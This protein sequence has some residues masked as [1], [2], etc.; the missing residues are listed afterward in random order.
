MKKKQFS[1]DGAKGA[2][3][4]GKIHLRLEAVNTAIERGWSPSP[5]ERKKILKARARALA[6]EPHKE[7]TREERKEILEFLLANE[8]YGI[9]SCYVREVYPLRELT[10]V[11]CTPPFVLG[12]INVRGRILP[13]IDIKKFF[14]LPQKGLTD[15]NK[16]IILQRN[17]M[18]IG[19]LSDAILGNRS[20]SLKEMQSSLP[21]LTDI[22]AEY[23]MGVTGERMVILDAAKILSDKRM[24]VHEQVEI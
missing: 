16:V 15:L 11:P 24:I 3:D 9:E 14:D 19:I 6:L 1:D 13:V 23:L 18:E 17:G 5:E 7:A 12:I 2:I 4:W 21:T 8:T 10:P 22:R 20:I